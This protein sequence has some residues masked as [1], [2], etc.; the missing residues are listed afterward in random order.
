MHKE[1]LL[2]IVEMFSSGDI[3]QADEIFSSN[4]LDHQKPE[5]IEEDGP[6]EF[7][8]IVASARKS[9][10]NLTV[11]IVDGFIV[12][13]DKVACRLS[14]FSDNAERETLEILRIESGKVAEHWG[15]EAWRKPRS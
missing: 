2:K 4:Y 10:P 13:G 12:D 7:K 11:N 6:G 5:W 9:L 1:L 3:S 15:A 14:W 8:K